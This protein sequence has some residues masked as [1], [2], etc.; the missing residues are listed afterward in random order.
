MNAARYT[1]WIRRN[2]SRLLLFFFALLVAGVVLVSRLELHA[3]FSELLPANNP[4]V[5]ELDRLRARIG[6]TTTFIVLLKSHSAERNRSFAEALEKRLQQEPAGTWRSLS[7]QTK[8]ERAFFAAHALLYANLEDLTAARDQLKREIDQRKTGAVSLED[9]VSPAEVLRQLEAK[10]LQVY[11]EQLT[12]PTGYFEAQEG[13]THK[14]VFVVRPATESLGG[15]ETDRLYSL[16]DRAVQ[17]TRASLGVQAEGVEPIYT[18]DIPGLLQEKGA[19]KEDLGLASGVCIVLVCLVIALYF[20]Q[21]RAVFLVAVPALFGTLLAFAFARLAIGYLNSNTAFLGSIILGNGINY[22]IIF[23]A[24]YREERLRG[25]PQYKALQQSIAETWKPTLAAAV[26]AST[27]YGSLMATQFRGFNQFG[28]IGSVGMLLC[29]GLT[30]T[31]LP[32]LVFALERLRPINLHTY[33]AG[34]AQP[35]AGLVLG[36]AFEWLTRLV[37]RRPG[38]TLFAL[39]GAFFLALGPVWTLGQ[40]PFEYNFTKL[41]N[42][43]S[44]TEG[45]NSHLTEVVTLFGRS[46]SP[47]VLVADSP[48]ELE[49]ARR[50]I[51]AKDEAKE[52]AGSAPCV[53][54]MSA[55]QD[56]LPAHQAQKLEVLR[57]VRNLTNDD[58][59][60]L[61]PKEQRPQLDEARARLAAYF[62]DGEARALTLNDLPPGLASV[63]TE[64]DGTRG[65][66]LHIQRARVV[67]SWEDGKRL[68]CFADST[69]GLTLPGGEQRSA[70]GQSQVFG[71]LIQSINEDGPLATAVAL[72]LVALLLLGT[73]RELRGFAVV[74]ATLLLGVGLMLGIAA[75]LGMRLNF[76]N[77]VA[78][79]ITFGIASEYGVN[80]YERGRHEALERL[81]AAIRGTGSAVALCSLTTII[82]YGT[83]LLSD[84]QALNSFGQLA[85]L[86][87]LTTLLCSLLF[88]PAALA[89]AARRQGQSP[90]ASA[91]PRS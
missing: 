91:A 63:F 50:A 39:S 86:G 87:E 84:N 56:Y 67:G 18:G 79:P 66:V 53:G 5:S 65:R 30:F 85:G 14:L 72:S 52:A 12:F 64:R 49:A 1:E 88:V 31:L 45:P 48:E 90:T 9:S 61:I 21:W 47:A 70:T 25:A 41:R 4:A 75:L 2:I 20:R 78:I 89:L 6:S 37:L 33:A 22:A 80:L 54:Q 7:Y 15:D 46:L 19:L 8:E 38:L 62:P 29:W 34:E 83:L 60:E 36:N 3:Q 68:L 43:R 11:Q 73:F 42:K 71:G 13:D 27:A 10:Y 58:A 26:G 17:D 51:I 69:I 32:A 35:R 74:L 23:L 76:L 57:Q 16:V 28:I 82:G 59:F 40:D 44:L 81:P 77:F 24:R 55:L